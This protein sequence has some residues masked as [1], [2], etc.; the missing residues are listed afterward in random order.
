MSSKEERQNTICDILDR[1]LRNYPEIL[2]NI[3]RD[4]IQQFDLAVVDKSGGSINQ[5][6]KWAYI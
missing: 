3:K 1:N 6:F 4:L 5:D 2:E